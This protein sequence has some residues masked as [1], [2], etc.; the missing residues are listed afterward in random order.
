[1]DEELKRERAKWEKRKRW[2]KWIGRGMMLLSIAGL[3][4]MLVWVFMERA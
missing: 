1:M 3:V 2:N 4:L